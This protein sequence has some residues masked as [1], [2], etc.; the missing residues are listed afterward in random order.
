MK[1]NMD[2][3]KKKS[4]ELILVSTSHGLPNAFRTENKFL[5]FMWLILFLICISTGCYTVFSSINDYLQYEVV[6]KI[7]INYE[8]PAH[9]PSLTIINTVIRKRF[10][11]RYVFQV[12][13]L[14][15]RG[16]D[17]KSI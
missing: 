15:Y 13:L 3:I 8:M 1:T 12:L 7:D 6:N 10:N 14:F 9:F 11:S 2:K 5:K 16:I 17:K 4:I